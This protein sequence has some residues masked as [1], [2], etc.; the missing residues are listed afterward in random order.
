MPCKTTK[1]PEE[2]MSRNSVDNAHSTSY[3]TRV[4][5]EPESELPKGL[6]PTSFWAKWLAEGGDQRC[7]RNWEY[8]LRRGTRSKLVPL[9][10]RK[11]GGRL[12]MTKADV[13]D[14]LERSDRT[15]APAESGTNTTT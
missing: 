6:L 10:H 12:F 9:K 8:N 15:K 5:N 1:P 2:S 4:Q 11:F 13:L 14:W 3:A 7:V